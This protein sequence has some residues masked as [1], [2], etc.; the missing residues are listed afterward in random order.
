VENIILE[1]RNRFQ[2]ET[3]GSEEKGSAQKTVSLRCPHCMHIGAFQTFANGL[4]FTKQALMPR[5]GLVSLEAFIRICPNPMC[6]G[7]VFT[8]SS[9]D[10]GVIA[11]PN[12]KLDFNP[13]GIPTNLVRTLE[14]A[15][16][17]HSAGAFR[18]A[19]MM[20]RRLLEEICEDSSAEGKNLHDRLQSLKSKITLP[21]ELFDAM[22][23]LKALGNDAAHV[24]AKDYADI[25][26]EE[27]EDSIELAQ[28]ILKARYQLRDL[29]D[30]LRARKS[31]NRD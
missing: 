24:F 28:E 21:L 23:E 17:C 3:S 27:A 2:I 7:I 25:G 6:K 13:D 5:K 10:E 8:I 1:N 19:A 31:K 18:A 29:L 4:S 12:E 14:E 16:S 15:V 9:G 26:K 22:G 11:L 20:V 30:R